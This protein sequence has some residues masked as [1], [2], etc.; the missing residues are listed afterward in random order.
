[1][2]TRT[3]TATRPTARENFARDVLGGLSGYPKKIP[4][5]YFYDARGD[6]L[7]Q[8][9]MQCPEY[10]LYR[11]EKA[12]L[13]LRADDM[14]RMAKEYAPSWEVMELGPGDASKSIFLLR[15]LAAEGCLAAYNPI[16]ISSHV[17]SELD[18]LLASEIPGIPVHGITG[19]YLEALETSPRRDGTRRLILFMGAG[20]GNFFPEEAKRFCRR[21]RTLT[22]PGDLVL[23]GF[24]LKKDPRR[25][26]DAYQDRG[27]LTKAFNLN[28]LA[29]INREAEG[30]FDTARFDHY[31]TYDPDTGSCKSFLVSTQE[32]VVRI[33]DTHIRFGQ[34]ETIFTEVSQKYAA[35][36]ID[37][38]AEASG[39][40]PVEHYTDPRRQFVDCL[41]KVPG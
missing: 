38:L 23:V 25:I 27:G 20:I 35:G 13:V 12:I 18:T 15:A 17:I 28:L 9:I 14:A 30:N 21:L 39:F 40:L 41:W 11:A 33:A 1:M 7:F 2:D 10:Y 4:S 37:L 16:D 36:E 26:L 22:T 19:D 32:T 3:D 29:R 24:D 5:K 8:Q 6:V 31:P 34:G